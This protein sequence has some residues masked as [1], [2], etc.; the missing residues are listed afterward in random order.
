V[1]RRADRLALRVEDG[2]L[3]SYEYSCFHG[4]SDYRMARGLQSRYEGSTGKSLATRQGLFP[5][6]AFW[7]SFAAEV[8]DGDYTATWPQVWCYWDGQVLA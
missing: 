7:R 1:E 4:N 3:R 2:G 6:M 5:T 8:R